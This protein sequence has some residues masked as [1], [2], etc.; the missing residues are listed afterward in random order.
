MFRERGARPGEKLA[1]QIRGLTKTGEARSGGEGA[2][3]LAQPEAAEELAS[4]M[5]RQMHVKTPGAACAKPPA[6]AGGGL[7]QG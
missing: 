7:G 3:S 1:E 2:G 6:L 5:L 4:A